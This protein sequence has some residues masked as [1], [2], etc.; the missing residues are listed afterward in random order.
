MDGDSNELRDDWLLSV[1]AFL[2]CGPYHMIGEIRIKA[3]YHPRPNEGTSTSQ[4]SYRNPLCRNPLF[5][6]IVRTEENDDD[7]DRLDEELLAMSEEDKRR[8]IAHIKSL[9]I[10]ALCSVLKSDV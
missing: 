7:I 10:C 4:R 5:G 8:A 6:N 2:S 3:V 1:K 9:H